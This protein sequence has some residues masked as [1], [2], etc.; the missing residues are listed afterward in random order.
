MPDVNFF[1]KTDFR[2]ENRLFGIKREDRR[3][4][5][6]VIGRTGMGKTSLLQNMILN[7]IYAG[8]GVCFIDPHGDAV[9]GLLDYIPPNRVDDVIYFNPA[10]TE[11]PI[12][13]NILEDVGPERRH[14]VVSSAISIF[15]KLFNDHWQHRQEHILRNT[16]LALLERPEKTTLLDV[17]RM[18]TDW[19]YRKKVAAEVIDPV[20]RSFW[21]NEFSK[22]VY[23]GKGESLAPILNKL[24]AFLSTPLVRNIVG[25][26]ESTFDFRDVMD[27]GK[28]LLVNVSQGRIG[29]DNSAFL[30]AV[31]VARLQL[32]AMSRIDV[33]ED[34]RRDFY[35]Y[36]DEFASFVSSD[37]FSGILSEA[38]KYRLC[39]TV[40]HQYIEQLDEKLRHS[41][42]GNVGS[43]L[44][45]PL[46]PEDAEYLEPHFYPE[47]R[48]GDI[49]GQAKHHIYL[50]MAIEGKT[51]QPFSAS[52]LMPFWG[53]KRCGLKNSIVEKSRS[54]FAGKMAIQEYFY[55]GAQT[56]LL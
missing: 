1:A 44:A 13:I 10:D 2:N 3:L 18:L 22:Y 14:L 20:V 39:L 21:Q 49:A 43:V 29:E 9:E 23:Q 6:Y 19:R 42:F 4:H 36:V 12:S 55:E 11:H 31:I 54:S 8:E 27:D 46:G 52:A 56:K 5:M 32:A 7:D 35:L 25:R 48:R 24:G 47:F 53:K 41:V 51:S 26:A 16:L 34:R 40:S 28:I 30:G 15:R 37:A 33:E 50:R 45:F 17:Y 38:R